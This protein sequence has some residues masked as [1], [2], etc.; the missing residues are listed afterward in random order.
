MLAVKP[1]EGSAD[2]M[3]Y[4]ERER[5][6]NSLFGQIKVVE[7]KHLSRGKA[8]LVDHK[9]LQKQVNLALRKVSAL[10]LPPEFNSPESLKE[11]K[12]KSWLESH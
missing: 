2:M 5:P 1:L 7:C 12:R 4:V 11:A 6:M 8:L 9:E 10:Y 3:H